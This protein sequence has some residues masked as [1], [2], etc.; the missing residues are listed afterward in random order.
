MPPNEIT[1]VEMIVASFELIKVDDNI[2]QPLV[3]SPSPQNIADIS[4]PFMPKLFKHFINDK[5][6]ELVVITSSSTNVKHITPPIN[7]IEFTDDIM[8]C[9]KSKGC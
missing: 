5:N 7:S 3:I 4:V 9:E 6:S 2:R 8:L 1:N